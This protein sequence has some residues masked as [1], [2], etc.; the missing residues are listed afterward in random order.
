MKEGEIFLNSY[1][2]HAMYYIKFHY[3]F[4]KDNRYWI[5]KTTRSVIKTYGKHALREFIL[6][7]IWVWTLCMFYDFP[8]H[9]G[10]DI[11]CNI[12][13]RKYLLQWRT[14]LSMKKYHQHLSF[15][16]YCNTQLLRIWNN[17]F[18]FE[19][20]Y[21]SILEQLDAAYFW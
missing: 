20:D 5:K 18:Y 9:T 10:K 15:S 3:W 21:N 4:S 8:T 16:N 19:I 12:K 14:K 6:H 2:A 7:S 11:G 13:Y 17:I 1:F